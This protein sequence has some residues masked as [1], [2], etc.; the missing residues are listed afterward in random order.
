A[1]REGRL[2]DLAS[3]I[4]SE[5]AQR[6]FVLTSD[7]VQPDAASRIAAALAVHEREPEYVVNN[8][9]FGMV[10]RAAALD[11]AEQLDMVD[12]NVR[13]LTELSL[14]FLTSIERRPGGILIVASVAGVR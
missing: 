6:P 13:A 11:R 1:G 12:L 10:G 3:E 5:G 2:N 4:A 7:L 9:G 14:A 8:A